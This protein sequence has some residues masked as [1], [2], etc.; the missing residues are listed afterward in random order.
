[1]DS[2]LENFPSKEKIYKIGSLPYFLNN[3]RKL[4]SQFFANFMFPYS[5][6]TPDILFA[7]QNSKKIEL[8][9]KIMTTSYYLNTSE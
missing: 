8:C 2:K 7:A 9:Q 3:G 4:G 1:M 5:T 6:Y